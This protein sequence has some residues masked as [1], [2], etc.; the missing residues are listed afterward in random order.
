MLV[1]G[2]CD[3]EQAVRSLLASFAARFCAETGI[4]LQLLSYST[5]EKLLKNHLLD[6]D[7]IFLEIPLRK[8]NGLKLAEHIRNYN[9]YVRIVFLTTVLTYVLEAYEVG[10]SNYLLKPLSYEK[11]SKE[12]CKVLEDK[13]GGVGRY[14]FEKN[15]QGLYKIYFHE[16]RYIETS[17]KSTLIH[18]EKADIPS[19]RQ[20]KQFEKLFA[21]T[22]LIRCHT[23]YIVN[24]RY[25][26]SLEGTMLVLSDGT[27][28]PVSRNRRP[29]LL[30]EIRQYYGDCL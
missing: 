4:Q 21:E 12:L 3:G 16:V 8:V 28:L 26:Q 27:R 10:A 19:S 24:L 20:M 29:L 9:K 25:F 18:T 14:F 11:F 5:G 15:R 7:M 1:I 13:Q 23:G 22:P 17:R 30:S 6:M 2:I